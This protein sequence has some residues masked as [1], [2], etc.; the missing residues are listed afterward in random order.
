MIIADESA[1][2]PARSTS[3]LRSILINGGLS[4]LAFGLLGWTVWKNREALAM[5]IDRDALI[6]QDTPDA[7]DDE[8]WE[9]VSDR[10]PPLGAP[11]TV[12]FIFSK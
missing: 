11:V 4:L 10:V 5:A 1:T 2:P 6:D 12:R 7:A 9:P 3:P 8:N